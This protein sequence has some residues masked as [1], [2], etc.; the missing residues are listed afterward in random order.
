MTPIGYIPTG[1]VLGDFEI[2]RP[3]SEGGMGTVYVANQ[4]GTGAQRALK[5]MR[6]GMM[7]DPKLRAR[8]E[9]ESRVS[10]LIRSDHVVQVVAAGVDEGSGMPWLAMELLE[11]R[12]LGAY[13][14]T[15][16]ALPMGEVAAVALQLGHA[17]R[18][19]HEVGVVHRDLKPENIFLAT[20]RMVGVPFVVKVLDFGVAKIMSEAH[21]A[22]M[23]LGTPAYMAPEQSQ[24]G[25]KIGPEADVWALGLIVYRMLTG[26]P[27][28]RASQS[29]EV[30]AAA[31]W[32]EALIEPIPTASNRALEQGV[33]GRLPPGFDAW[34]AR[35]VEREPSLRF[36]NGGDAY[37]AL[38]PMLSMHLPPG[39]FVISSGPRAAAKPMD[40]T[41]DAGAPSVAVISAAL[42]QQHATPSIRKPGVHPAAEQPTPQGA[43][44]G[45]S[46]RVEARTVDVTPTEMR[47]PTA[48]ALASSQTGQELRQG[49][50]G[51]RGAKGQTK[52]RL[53]FRDKFERTIVEAP[54]GA[55]LLEVSL[56][57]GIP[58]VH[59]CGG[60]ARCSTCR[61]V[62]LDGLQNLGA[63]N[64][65][66]QRVA[67]RK[68]WPD[69][70]RLACQTQ[71][72]GDASLR[73]LIIDA[74]DE[75]IAQ[76]EASLEDADANPDS[77]GGA[78]IEVRAVALTCAIK[79]FGAFVAANLLHDVVH[80]VNRYL[81]QVCEPVL[82]NRGRI[83]QYHGEAVTSLFGLDRPADGAPGSQ[84][85]GGA[86]LPAGEPHEPALDAL[87]AALR[88]LARVKQL[89]Q[90]LARNFGAEL[91]VTIGLHEGPLVIARVGHPSKRERVALGDTIEKATLLAR[92]AQ[93]A[94]ARILASPSF[95]EK[96]GAEAN[97]GKLVAVDGV[98]ESAEVLD[99]KRPDVVFLVQSTF[100]RVAPRADEV[101]A[102]FYERLFEL[103]PPLAP[104]F[105]HVD[106]AVQR[107]MLMKMLAAAVRGLDHME[108]LVPILQDLGRRHVGY[109]TRPIHYKYVGQ[110]LIEALE[111]FFGA[112]FTPE[113][114][115]AW[116]EIYSFI[117]RNMIDGARG[118]AS[119]GD[120][121]QVA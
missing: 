25:A 81:R 84:P 90:Y 80:V 1:A 82:A 105:D 35:C 37:A 3:L 61:V 38:A 109:G 97:I 101:S 26:K 20:A 116:L 74:E 76:S 111:Q 18:A 66:E 88:M 62:V 104:L 107:T 7:A 33:E 36:T 19:A 55:T 12:D 53:T 45:S 93:A 77:L 85:E 87:R 46:P 58:H 17:L 29:S 56:A 22:T 113:V 47:I 30:P 120:R 2:V 70:I 9:Q 32:R 16:G 31:L 106:M 15:V 112:D 11:G 67:D 118:P 54:Y 51:P 110:A 40:D 48:A 42:A 52:A 119:T 4:R 13:L 114:H 44:P 79:D 100:E 65:A 69:N 89:N 60:R 91:E 57:N 117:A 28:W 94:G 14:A 68:G 27:F 43:F 64:E 8:F 96:L 6:S 78:A 39:S 75:A 99:F 23:A 102:I 5:V 86:A 108:S 115:L 73:R 83:E 98:G 71:V 103:H 59:V 34:F 21:A 10:G 92:A 121:A 49:Q 63:R 24:V 72:N 50:T 41:S 95:V